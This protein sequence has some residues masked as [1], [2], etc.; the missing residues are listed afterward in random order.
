MK[1][2][3]V[4]AGPGGSTAA[5]L[6]A[7]QRGHEVVLLDRDQFPRM[8]TC[9][10]GLGPRCLTLCK[11]I[12]LFNR[13][14]SLALG[15]RGCRFVGPSGTEAVLAG[16]SDEAWI[17]PRATFDSEIAFT[18]EREGARFLQ[19]F[20]V[21]RALRDAAGRICGVSDGKTEIEADLVIFAEGAHTRFSVDRRKRRQIAAIMA[22]YEGVPYTR[23]VLEM[24]FDKRVRPWY[25]WLFPE[26]DTRVNVGICYDPDDAEDPKKILNEVIERN[27]GDRLRGAE[28]V[29]K[30]R[31]HPIVYTERVGPIAA[32]GAL[33]IGEAAR[34][35]NAATGEG[36]SYAM[37]S[38][39][40]AAAAIAD[41]RA[42][43]QALYDDYT[44]RTVRSFT[45]PLQ[46]A[47]GFMN[48]VGTPAFSMV[49]SLITHRAV[50]PPL[51]WLLANV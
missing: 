23:G 2:V 22:W 17:I 29:G 8:K 39:R 35:T 28:Q 41:H 40:V 10:S 5:M 1:I 15:I 13:M 19:G 47:V 33:W 43:G 18:A 25:G 30:Y 37:R 50:Q 31:G 20:N 3:I 16:P 49:S 42:P 45:L 24:F 27:V 38:A 7:Q 51:R 14:K 36:I 32:P 11:E 44:R 21:K 9:G 46:T 12:G 26:T 6:L 34:L 48:F 4:G